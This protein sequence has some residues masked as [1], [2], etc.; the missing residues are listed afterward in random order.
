MA[1]YRL[2]HS[3]GARNREAA[4]GRDYEVALGLAVELVDGDSECLAPP[5]QQ[6]SAQGFAAAC[7]AAYRES[8]AGSRRGRR[9]HQFQRRRGQE[10]VAYAEIADQ[11][12]RGFRI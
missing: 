8:T 7:D 12:E 11:L 6:L 5:I 3:P 4:A 1:G 2:A 9:S 10:C